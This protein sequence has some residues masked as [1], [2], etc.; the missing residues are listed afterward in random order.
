MDA[1]Y[2]GLSLPFS[3]SFCFSKILRQKEI[4]STFSKKQK[5]KELP[6]NFTI[7]SP[8]KKCV[9]SYLKIEKI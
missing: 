9:K 1:N 6:S 2:K 3:T 7:V 5:K 8:Y 4:T